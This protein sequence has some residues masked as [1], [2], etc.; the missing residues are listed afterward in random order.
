MAYPAIIVVLAVILLVV[1]VLHETETPVA[2]WKSSQ[3][4]IIFHGVDQR[5]L[6]NLGQETDVAQVSGMQRAAGKALVSLKS[7]GPSL[8]LIGVEREK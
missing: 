8:Q 1:T 7:R 6:H 4:A 5:T 3:L 2:G